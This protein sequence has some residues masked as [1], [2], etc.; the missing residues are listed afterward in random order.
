M[1]CVLVTPTLRLQV[2]FAGREQILRDIR[3]HRRSLL[4]KEQVVVFY[5]PVLMMRYLGTTGLIG[6]FQIQA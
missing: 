4:L 6:R 3:A 2:I 5:L 1:A